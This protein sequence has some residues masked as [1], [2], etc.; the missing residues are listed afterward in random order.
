MA[1]QR[2]ID[3]A[4]RANYKRRV[5]AMRQG[6]GMKWTRRQSIAFIDRLLNA[7]KV[8]GIDDMDLRV[9]VRIYNREISS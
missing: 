8:E 5:L 6:Y 3:E 4:M 9:L 1:D 2:Q 7:S